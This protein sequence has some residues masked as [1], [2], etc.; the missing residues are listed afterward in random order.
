MELSVSDRLILLSI[1][2][3]EG[4]LTTLRIV[5]DLQSA[6]S[7]S[8]DEHK[9]LKF[10]QEGEKVLWD[11]QP[12]ADIDI[13]PRAHVLVADTLKDLGAKKKLQLKQ[14]PLYEKFEPEARA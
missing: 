5:R 13:G 1:L 10:R 14:L 2:P 4:D 12:P 8:E 9:T 11:E 7:F 6:L 3:Q